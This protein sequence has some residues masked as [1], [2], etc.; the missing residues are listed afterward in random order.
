MTSPGPAADSTEALAAA[1]T[2]G[3]SAIGAVAFESDA[4]RLAR[5]RRGAGRERDQVLDAADHA[6]AQE[7]DESHE[8][9]AEHQPPGAAEMQRVLEEVAEIEPDGRADQ[10]AE[11][12]AGAADRGLHHELTRGVEGEGVGRHEALHQAEQAAGE[13]GAGR[14]YDEVR[15]LRNA[16]HVVADCCSC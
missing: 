10:R 16:W 9:E 11:Q 2:R 13:A 12:R 8:H 1:K 4:A 7:D 14:G 3:C 5:L 15:Q 6:A